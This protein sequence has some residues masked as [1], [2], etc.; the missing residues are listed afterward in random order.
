MEINTDK[1]LVKDNKKPKHQTA[2]S[3]DEIIKIVGESKQYDYGYWLRKVKNVSYAKVL[4]I[5]KEASNLD[6][7]YNRGGY[8][9]NK[10]KCG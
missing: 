7:K 4:Q 9:T 10:L 6:K 5:C 1:Y 8:I 2:A 3:V